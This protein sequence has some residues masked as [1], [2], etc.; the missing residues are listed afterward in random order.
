MSVL[1]FEKAPPNVNVSAE[2]KPSTGHSIVRDFVLFFSSPLKINKCLFF[3]LQ[4]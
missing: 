1:P 3:L 4:L 2:K